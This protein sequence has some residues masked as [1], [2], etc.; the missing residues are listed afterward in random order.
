MSGSEEQFGDEETLLPDATAPGGAR[1]LPETPTR[2]EIGRYLILDE[3]GRGAMGVVFAA[4]DPQLDRKVAL[5]LIQGAPNS[6]IAGERLLREAQAMARLQHPNVIAVHDAG[7]HLGDVYVAM[8]LFDGVTL[9]KWMREKHGWRE[10][11]ELFLSAAA[12][13]SAA[14][15]AGLVHRDFKPANV[16]V[17]PRGE[18][19]VLD[20]GLARVEHR[21][22]A[23]LESSQPNDM[24]LTQTGKVMG[25][26]AYMAPEQWEGAE[27]NAAADQFAFC[28][29]LFEALYGQRPF[30]GD[31]TETLM[32]SVLRGKPRE[33]ERGDV[34][35]G[36]H[37]VVLRGL[38]PAKADRF[39]S[40]DALAAALRRELVGRGRKGIWAAVAV[41]G[42]GVAAV[43][44]GQAEPCPSARERLDGVWDDAVAGGIRDAFAAIDTAL[45]GEAAERVD[46]SLARYAEGWVEA[47]REACEATRVLGRQSEEVLSRRVACLERHRTAL[48]T[49]TSMLQGIDA[50]TVPRADRI[51]SA[52]EPHARCLAI[53]AL[54]SGRGSAEQEALVLSAIDEAWLKSAAG[55]LEGA[56]ALAEGAAADADGSPWLRSWATLAHAKMVSEAGR[57]TEATP[58]FEA[59]LTAALETDD[60]GLQANVMASLAYGVAVETP[61]AAVKWIDRAK[62]VRSRLPPNPNEEAALRG[63]AASVYRAAG[64]LDDALVE[65]QRAVELHRGLG[66]D[67]EL[68]LSVALMSIGHTY[69]DLERAD[70]AMEAYR[71]S[72]SLRESLHG[73]HHPR[74]AASLQS[75]G[76]AHYLRKEYE[77]AYAAMA[78]ALPILEATLGPDDLSVAH[79]V[80]NM[81]LAAMWMDRFDEAERLLRRAM[82]IRK[83]VLGAD[84][85]EVGSSLHNL[86]DLRG[87]QSQH[88]EARSLYAAALTLKENTFG[89]DHP[90]LRSSLIG[91][92]DTLVKLDRPTEAI[93]HYERAATLKQ[94]E[95]LTKKLE[96]ARAQPVEPPAPVV[97]VDPVPARRD[98]S[99]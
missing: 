26:P 24:R 62:A 80:N 14:H 57:P 88:E 41:V 79:T 61:Q 66:A 20:F 90:R 77:A 32:A 87:R 51:V 81:G 40:M 78:E 55:D 4:Y 8:E 37:A 56:I 6:T 60:A 91:L 13:L 67:G 2:P 73:K 39:A 34:P 64:L 82:A 22:H 76:T 49:V 25:T 19:K 9:A 28:V 33:P 99:Q 93:P 46:A 68:G 18:V 65:A 44:Y 85:G 3:L 30:D 59:A 69:W 94:S 16:M 98:Q 43:Y 5:K 75:I 47:N 52:L 50:G 83:N 74:Y 29:A 15:Q 17:G 23:E 86:G 36:I 27:L 54:A 38:A 89:K 45:A 63:D 58:L 97:P 96:T 84:H 48:E 92:A 72:A 95:A 42:I 35:R 53:D 31:R 1:E 10:T 12:G 70:D 7:V 71:E 11:C 21:P